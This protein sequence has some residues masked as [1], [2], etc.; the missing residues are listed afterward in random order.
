M[1]VVVGQRASRS[2]V[3]TL[4][5]VKGYAKL[6]GDYNPLHFDASFVARTKFKQL[7]VQGG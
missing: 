6:M 5:D 1:D 7:V 4:D 3:L 2:K